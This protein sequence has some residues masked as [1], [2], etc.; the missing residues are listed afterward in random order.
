MTAFTNTPCP[1]S[2]VRLPLQDLDT[3]GITPAPELVAHY[4]ATEINT[5]PVF[6]ELLPGYEWRLVQGH[7]TVAAMQAAGLTW[8]WALQVEPAAFQAERQLLG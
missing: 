1:F 5:V 4:A 6:V 8:V 2:P 3:T 7:E